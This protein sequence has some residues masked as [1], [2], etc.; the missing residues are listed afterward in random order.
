MVD[1]QFIVR[2][3]ACRLAKLQLREGLQVRLNAYWN[4]FHRKKKVEN[5][6]LKLL[7][8]HATGITGP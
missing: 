7:M 4:K 5:F 8:S 1:G 2:I 6:H 3:R